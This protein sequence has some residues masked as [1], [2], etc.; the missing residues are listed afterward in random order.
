MDKQHL[1]ENQIKYSYIQNQSIGFMPSI[2][3]WTQTIPP[4][5]SA[6]LSHDRNR[7]LVQWHYHNRPVS[8]HL[9]KCTRKRKHR[10]CVL[11]CEIPSKNS[12][13][14]RSNRARRIKGALLVS[15]SLSYIAGAT[16]NPS[17]IASYGNQ[18]AQYA[19]G[20]LLGGWLIGEKNQ[21][22]SRAEQNTHTHKQCQPIV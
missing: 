2:S 4:E 18:F 9:R 1:L 7:H 6:R 19:C 5:S 22:I 14:L 17:G 21:L 15:V 16:A 12:N 8:C 3:A 10:V 20:A 11:C 13:L